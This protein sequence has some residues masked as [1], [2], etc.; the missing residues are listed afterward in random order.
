M[1]YWRG[2]VLT[3]LG[4]ILTVILSIPLGPVPAILPLLNP[5]PQGIWSGAKG[6][7]PQGA[8][9]LNLSGLIAPV[10]VS[11]STGGVPHI[12]A[13]NNHDLFF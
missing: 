7:V 3:A 11:Y 1:R 4:I 13:Q 10:R 9:T 6:A 12:F 5:A 2:G 8:G